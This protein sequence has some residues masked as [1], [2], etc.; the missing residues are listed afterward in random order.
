MGYGTRLSLYGF[1]YL[2]IPHS[3]TNLPRQYQRLQN[4][5]KQVDQFQR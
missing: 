4:L 2:S 5:C 3:S 1:V